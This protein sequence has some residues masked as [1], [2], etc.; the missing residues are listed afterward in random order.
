MAEYEPLDLSSLCNSGLEALGDDADAPVGR[1]EFHGLPFLIGG[2]DSTASSQCFLMLREGHAVSV[3]VGKQA[4]YVVFAHR[5]MQSDLMEG[6]GLGRVVA[7]YV[8]HYSDAEQVRIPVRERFVLG[9]HPAQSLA[10]HQFRW[11]NKRGMWS[12]PI[13]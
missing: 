7:E 12:L 1:Q 2:R 13:A 8:F 6:K 9:H 5:L 3:P 10:L 4:R 11:E